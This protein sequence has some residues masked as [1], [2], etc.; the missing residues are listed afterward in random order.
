MQEEELLHV[1]RLIKPNYL[2]FKVVL[3]ESF[4]ESSA[5]FYVN[6]T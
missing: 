6:I 4:S 2:D 5:H 1:F 3:E